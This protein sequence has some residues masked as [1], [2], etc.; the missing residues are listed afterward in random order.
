MADDTRP[1]TTKDMEAIANAAAER[2]L[3]KVYGQIGKNIVTRIFWLAGVAALGFAA[4]KGW[5][6]PGGGGSP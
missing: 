6:T 1:L 3:E 2:A 5:F 4:A